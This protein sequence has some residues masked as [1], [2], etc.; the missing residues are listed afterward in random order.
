MVAAGQLS[1]VESE[2]LKAESVLADKPHDQHIVGHVATIRACVAGLGGDQPQALKFART[3]MQNLPATDF[4]ARGMAGIVLG[5]ALRWRGDLQESIQAYSAAEEAGRKAGDYFIT[6]FSFCYQGYVLIM[7]GQLREAHETLM[8]ALDYAEK[9]TRLGGWQPPIAGLAHAFLCGVLLERNNLE[10]ALTHAQVGLELSNQWGHVHAIL[11]SYF[12]L[13]SCLLASGAFDQT[14][15]AIFEAKRIA[16]A[17]SEMQS[18]VIANLEIE[19]DIATGDLEHAY[20]EIACMGIDA[21]DDI[22][23]QRLD[24]YLAL[25]KTLH[26][27]NKSER[28]IPLLERL[29]KTAHEAGAGGR[30]IEILTLLALAHRQKGAHDRATALMDQAIRLAE[31]EGI[32]HSIIRHGPPL[33]DLLR[34]AAAQGVSPGYIGELLAELKNR[35][36]LEAWKGFSARVSRI[37]PLSE[38]ELQVLRLLVAGQ[39]STEVARELTI[40][41]GTARTHIKH[42]YRK[43]GV[44]KRLEAV[45]KAKLLGFV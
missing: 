20:Q 33:D 12:F 9:S 3:A 24:H 5:L 34:A 13:I 27:D 38:R 21:G 25:A 11:D 45:E 26:A 19:L 4:N 15:E 14:R 41:V 17:V 39:S 32:V 31:P 6:I 7:R 40:A 35:T 2:L 10:Q 23:F 22:L 36:S 18:M 30:V 43:L 29:L 37:E 8:R 44:H 1:T 28:A 42:I 16:T